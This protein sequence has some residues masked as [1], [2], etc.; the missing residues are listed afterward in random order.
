MNDD[1]KTMLAL[2]ALTYRG[3]GLH[4]EAAV[5]EALRPWLPKLEAEGLG[6]WKLVWG[7]ATFRTAT[8]LFDDAMMYVARETVKSGPTR[9]AV[10]I[11]GTNPVS[12][13]DWV[14]GDLWVQLQIDQVPPGDPPARLA[15]STALGVAII[16]RLA[17]TVPPSTTHLLAPLGGAL[18]NLL[19]GVAPA[20]PEIGPAAFW[21]DPSSFT[22]L[23]LKSRIAALTDA[24]GKV[25]RTDVLGRLLKRFAPGAQPVHAIDRHVYDRLL[26]QIETAP[27]DGESVLGFLNRSVEPGSNVAV[28]GHSK[29]G[30]LAVAV[31]LWLAESWAAAHG[32]EI[33]CF[34][35][36]GPTAGNEAFVHRYNQKLGERT[37]RIVN[38]RDVVPQA[39]VPSEIKAL[40]PI[41]PELGPAL[42]GLADRIA[43]L[44]YQH[45]GGEPVKIQSRETRGFLID[46]IIHHHLDAYLAA[47]GLPSNRGWTAQSLFLSH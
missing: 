27:G 34:S 19:D 33:E 7:P 8:S 42:E 36:A 32:A 14:F 28:T 2:A 12:A 30:A 23:H 16:Q 46:D 24:A 6:E 18:A 38:P 9:Y 39:W 29:G 1:E 41:Y 17:A 13:F 25:L 10:A 35:F 45:V 26:H 15:A 22:E 40:R 5:D 20:L 3:F 44:G 43:P 4:S 21:K 37:H 11:R 31:A 47:A